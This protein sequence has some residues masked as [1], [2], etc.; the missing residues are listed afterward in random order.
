[1]YVHYS[2]TGTQLATRGGGIACM[3]GPCWLQHRAY[4]AAPLQLEVRRALRAVPCPGSKCPG[5][6]R[7]NIYNWVLG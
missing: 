6:N 4:T 7:S 5:S 3:H 2:T 1:M